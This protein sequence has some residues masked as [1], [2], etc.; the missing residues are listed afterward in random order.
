MFMRLMVLA[1]LTVATYSGIQGNTAEAGGQGQPTDWTNFNHYPYIYY[2]HNFQKPQQ[3][4]HMYYR[5]PAE[6]RIPVFN[7]DWH[8]FYLMEQ[9]YYMGYHDIMDVF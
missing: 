3:F 1:I 4:N 7:K 9:P 2:P 6:R 5:Y 8:N